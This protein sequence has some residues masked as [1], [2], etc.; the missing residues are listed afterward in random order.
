VTS[1]LSYVYH[2]WILLVYVGGIYF[3]FFV[4][5]RVLRAQYFI[6]R[7][8]IWTVLGRV[9]ATLFASVGPCFVGPIL[10]D[11]TFDAQM[12]YLHHADE[13]Y[14]VLVLPVQQ[15]LLGWHQLHSHD[16]AGGISAMPS[17]HV[18]MA[19]LTALAV[20]PLSKPVGALAYALVV[21]ILL[22][23]VHLAYHYAVDG[24]A[25]LAGTWAL[26]VLSGMW[27]RRI[28]ARNVRGEGERVRGF[29]PAAA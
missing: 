22:G 3:A 23:S 18:A 25:S 10:G 8:A 21:V 4:R 7:L 20:W 29:E 24:L 19:L 26:W 11:H 6:A 2:A 17:M 5:D 9:A 13:R 27:A 15:L 16:F 28:V 1:L 12:A 14:H